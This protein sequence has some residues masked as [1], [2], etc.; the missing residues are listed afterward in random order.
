MD[1]RLGA[2]TDGVVL[3]GWRIDD[4]PASRGWRSADAG[5]RRAVGR[6]ARRVAE[7]TRRRDRRP[8]AVS[9]WPVAAPTSSSARS[10]GTGSAS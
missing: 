2:D 9:W 5:G 6:P 8:G 1:L 10:A 4:L 7:R 3:R